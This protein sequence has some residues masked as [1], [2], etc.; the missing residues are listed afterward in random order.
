ML[1]IETVL[2]SRPANIESDRHHSAPAEKGF[3]HELEAEQKKLA[4]STV[5]DRHHSAR[6]EVGRAEVGHHENPQKLQSRRPRKNA[7]TPTEPA[8]TARQSLPLSAS[9]TDGSSCPVLPVSVPADGTPNAGLPGAV[10]P[11]GDSAEGT[12]LLGIAGV[13]AAPV[14]EP[15]LK[16]VGTQVHIEAPSSQDEG[17]HANSA[18]DATTTLSLPEKANQPVE[19]TR[20]PV[21]AAAVAANGDGASSGEPKGPQGTADAGVN[22]AVLTMATVLPAGAAAAAVTGKTEPKAGNTADSR[23]ADTR[24]ISRIEQSGQNPSVPVE[25][26]EALSLQNGGQ[27]GGAAQQDARGGGYPDLGGQ[28]RQMDSRVDSLVRKSSSEGVAAGGHSDA[29]GLISVFGGRGPDALEASHSFA[30][31][32]ASSA[33]QSEMYRQIEKSDVI[34]QLVDKARLF[35]WENNTEL[36]IS[37]KP[38]ALGQLTLRASIVDR[39]LMATI[40]ADSD[41]VRHLLVQE[42]PSLHRLLR[43]DGMLAKVEVVQGNQGNHLDFS[44]PGSGQPQS[45]QNPAFQGSSGNVSF[46]WNAQQGLAASLEPVVSPEIADSRYL[47][48]SIHLIA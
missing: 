12:S 2:P 28:S 38:E 11:G 35:K 33:G 43:E 16:Q 31:E 6:S 36:Q 37:L 39:T 44:S 19:G 42:M 3:G 48:S 22:P 21:A 23:S 34:S 29:S 18:A 1:N 25:G 32:L 5:S 17:D 41:K 30:S 40:T 8:N 9:A 4:D 15:A 7:K 14:D 24:A 10:A 45:H 20:P 47:S 46:P 13:G 27:S 26:T